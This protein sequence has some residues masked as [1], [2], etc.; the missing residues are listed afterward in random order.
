MEKIET[1]IW[2]EKKT[3]KKTCTKVKEKSQRLI[4]RDRGKDVS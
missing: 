3:V 1:S 4:L 2:S